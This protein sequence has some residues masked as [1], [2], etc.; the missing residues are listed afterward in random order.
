MSRQDE[1]GGT[2]RLLQKGKEE[3]R[4]NHHDLETERSDLGAAGKKVS[5]NVGGKRIWPWSWGELPRK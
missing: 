2:F 4:Q 5:Y 1:R 3:K